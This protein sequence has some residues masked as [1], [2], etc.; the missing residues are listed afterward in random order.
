MFLRTPPT[1]RGWKIH[2]LA[3][4]PHVTA[5][6]IPLLRERIRDNPGYR[7]RHSKRD[8]AYQSCGRDTQHS[9]LCIN[10]WPARKTGICRGIRAN[11]A[12]KDMIRRQD[13]ICGIDDAAAGR[14]LTT[15]DQYK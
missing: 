1:L 2:Q 8:P 12:F 10:Q 5:I 4:D 9:S 14:A 7:R 3:A 6:D 11:I 13:Q 15:I